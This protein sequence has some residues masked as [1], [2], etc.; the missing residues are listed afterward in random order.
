V[1]EHAVRIPNML[2]LNQTIIP[3]RKAAIK[4]WTTF[5]RIA[6]VSLVVQI[7]WLRSLEVSQP[8]PT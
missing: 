6:S 3:V 5:R 4:R 7:S 8:E 2:L 1:V